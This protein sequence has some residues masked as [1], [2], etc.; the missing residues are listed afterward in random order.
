MRLI[1]WGSMHGPDMARAVAAEQ[2]RL[3]AAADPRW[4][5]VW[6][7]PL[8]DGPPDGRVPRRFVREPRCA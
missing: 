1:V 3:H 5:D 6:T 2:A 8:Y 7:P 4:W